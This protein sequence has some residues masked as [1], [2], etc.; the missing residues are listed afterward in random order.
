MNKFF[1][2]LFYAFCG[3]L[4]AICINLIISTNVW[5]EM[6]IHERVVI[7]VCIV[8]G[9]VVSLIKSSAS[10]SL[11]YVLQSAMFLISIWF[12]KTHLIYYIMRNFYLDGVSIATIK[13]IFLSFLTLINI[14]IV[15][16]LVGKKFSFFSKFS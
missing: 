8:L 13:I 15:Y 1:L 10:V 3:L 4:L 12:T 14:M 16:H 11:F 7:E 5:L 9:I 2:A 6:R